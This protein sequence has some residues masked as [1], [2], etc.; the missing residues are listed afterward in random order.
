MAHQQTEYSSLK[1]SNKRNHMFQQQWKVSHTHNSQQL[2]SPRGKCPPSPCATSSNSATTVWNEDISCFAASASFNMLLIHKLLSILQVCSIF[3]WILLPGF[4]STHKVK[5]KKRRT[6]WDCS[7]KILKFVDSHKV[8]RVFELQ[9]AL[10]S[11]F[12]FERSTLLSPLVLV[13][14]IWIHQDKE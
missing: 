14:Y 1:Q 8:L 9:P 13:R 7:K 11:I 4:G 2:K 10:I 3:L 6:I 5:T 12:M